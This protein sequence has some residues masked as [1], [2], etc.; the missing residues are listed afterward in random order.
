MIGSWESMLWKLNFLFVFSSYRE[1]LIATV[2]AFEISLLCPLI[3][4]PS[5]A[6]SV[7]PTIYKIKDLLHMNNA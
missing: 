3:S 2:A 1:V 4:V 6:S 5:V 7:L